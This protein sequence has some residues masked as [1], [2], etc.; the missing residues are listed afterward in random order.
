[1]FSSPRPHRERFWKG[2]DRLDVEVMRSLT[3][4]EEIIPSF[5]FN[6]VVGTRYDV[7]LICQVAVDNYLY[8]FHLGPLLV[9]RG[10][11]LN[12]YERVCVNPCAAVIHDF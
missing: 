7:F 11:G 6:H 1:M 2:L 12:F 10:N 4:I 8:L 9:G 3:S 5:V